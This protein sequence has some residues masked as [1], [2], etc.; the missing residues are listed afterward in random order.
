MSIFERTQLGVGGLNEITNFNEIIKL[1]AGS[2]FGEYALNTKG[3]GLRL[4]RVQCIEDC[5]FA[6]VN[7]ANY[8]KVLEKHQLYNLDLKVKFLRQIPFLAHWSKTSLNRFVA[9][10]TE[11]HYVRGNRIVEEGGNVEYVYI[12]KSGEFEVIK[13]IN[14]N[15]FNFKF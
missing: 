12:V 14:Y 13:Q 4:A 3:G 15:K 1:A 11:K 6:I 2:S 5:A 9:A 7:K 8:Q 10:L